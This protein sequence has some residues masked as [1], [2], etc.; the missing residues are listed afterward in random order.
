MKPKKREIFK[1]I[2]EGLK[3]LGILAISV[4]TVTYTFSFLISGIA[5]KDVFNILEGKNVTLGID[6]INFLI[7]I[8]VLVPLLINGV[9][10]FNFGFVEKI[11]TRLRLNIKRILLN[12]IIKNSLNGGKQSEGA[13]LNYYR[14]ECEDIVSYYMEFYYQMP[15]IILSIS[16]L[17]VIF[18]INPVFAVVSL[19][20]TVLM[21]VLVKILSRKIYA[22]RNRSRNNT[23]EVVTFLNAFFEYTEFFY[24]VR[25]KEQ[26]VSLYGKKCLERSKSEIKDRVLD[27]VLGAISSNS[28]NI[29]LGIVLLIALPFMVSGN[30]TV[31]EFV[32]FGYYY[33]FLT[34]LPDAIANLV[35]RKKQTNASLERIKFLFEEEPFIDSVV[36]NDGYDFSIL[37]NQ[38][39][40]EFHFERKGLVILKG[41]RSGDCLLTMF[42]ACKYFTPPI[43][44]VYVPKEPVLLDENLVNNIVM[45]DTI[46]NDK[47]NDVLN[48]VE[49]SKDVDSFDEGIMKKCGKKGENL[50]GGQRKRAGIA[51]ALYQDADILFVDGLTDRVDMSTANSL[52]NNIMNKFDGLL[53]LSYEEGLQED[54]YSEVIEV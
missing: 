36:K 22:I 47:L 30:F 37:C 14:N 53:I 18:F 15:K 10:Q 35:K 48:K 1:S 13:F 12:Y 29:A 11:K 44:C 16:I 46:I 42:K 52:L 39:K 25:E 5:K 4:E 23:K 54:Y 38:E 41:E 7:L 17:L 45:G 28:S 6:S 33:A 8:I 9:K 31:G 27:S 40:R 49:L 32:M 51:R 50:S 2:T 26:L 43:R 34:Y 19:L 21:V 20:P 3:L 24:M